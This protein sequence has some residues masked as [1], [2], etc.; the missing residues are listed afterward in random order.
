M[1]EHNAA[2]YH[3]AACACGTGIRV[4]R[5]NKHPVN[6]QNN[7]NNNILGLQRTSF[8]CAKGACPNKIDLNGRGGATKK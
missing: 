3:S 2:N 7:N 6:V 1:A 8:N 4:R 5:E